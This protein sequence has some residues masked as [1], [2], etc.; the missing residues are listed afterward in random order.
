LSS[1]IHCNIVNILLILFRD[2]PIIE[3]IESIN[4][5]IFEGMLVAVIDTAHEELE[6]RFGVPSLPAMV[7]VE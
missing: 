4:K 7:Y 2:G 1:I 5:E 3:K 6:K